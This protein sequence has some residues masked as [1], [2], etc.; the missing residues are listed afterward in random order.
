MTAVSFARLN[1]DWKIKV[2]CSLSPCKEESW[3]SFEQ[4][5][6]QYKGC[7]YFNKLSDISN[8]K[9]IPWDFNTIG[10]TN[11]ISEVFKSDIIRLHLLATEGGIWSDFDVYFFSSISALDCNTVENKNKNTILC[12]QNGYHSIGFLGSSGNNKYFD[13]LF[14]KSKISLDKNKYQSIGRDLFRVQFSEV[15]NDVINLDFENVY[16]VPWDKLDLIWGNSR[17]QWPSNTIGVHWFAGSPVTAQ[18]ENEV[19]RSNLF[20]YK[21]SRLLNEIQRDLSLF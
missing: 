10:I 18:I 7:D 3:L 19:D 20:K 12:F 1:P 2:H 4:K 15:F 6:S 8:L 14:Q 11:N 9:I 21:Q 17:F 5:N 16:P 13:E